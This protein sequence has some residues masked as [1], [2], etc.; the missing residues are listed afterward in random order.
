[1]STPF[2]VALAFTLK[3]EGGY[4]NDPDDAGGATN[5]GITQ[6][7]YDAHRKAEGLPTLSVKAIT[8]ATVENIYR[9]EY[10]PLAAPFSLPLALAVF[11][12]AVN[13]G[14]GRAKQFLRMIAGMNPNR[15]VS[16]PVMLSFAVKNKANSLEAAHM[17]IGM[18]K[19]W[20][21]SRVTSDS[22]QQK[23]LEGWLARDNDLAKAVD[24]LS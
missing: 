24:T 16:D 11:D 13:F 4:T 23:F 14:T 21:L 1:V 5:Y 7:T 10:W 9:N 17:L 19:A 3:H 12:T 22:S 6:A 8:M 18:R 20:R 15:D 2:D